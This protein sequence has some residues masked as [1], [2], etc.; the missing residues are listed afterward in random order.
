MKKLS[1]IFFVINLSTSLLLSQV[2][3]KMSYQA[4]VRNTSGNPIVNTMVGIKISILQESASGTTIYAET[5]TPT[6]NQ[7]GLISIEIGSGSPVVGTFSVINWQT[8][9]FFI[10]TE[11]DLLGG[12]NY[13]ITSTT[14]LLSVP[15]SI[16]SKTS[17]SLPCYT[18][19]ERDLLVPSEGIVVFNK[20]SKKPNY[21]DGTIWRNYDNTITTINLTTT[22]LSSVTS[23]SADCGGT[24]ISDGGSTITT[25]GVCWSTSSNPTI[26]LATRT[27]EIND[28]KTFTSLLTGLSGNTTYY[29]RAYATNSAGTDYGNEIV[30]TTPISSSIGDV[31]KGGKI[32]YFL[33]TGDSGYDPNIRHGLIIGNRNLTST[34]WGCDNT[35][36]IGTTLTTLGS[37]L[38][39]TN[40][41]IL[42]SCSQGAAYYCANLVQGGYNDWFLPSVDE[43]KKISTNYVVLNLGNNNSWSSTEKDANNAWYVNFMNGQQ[44]SWGKE[45]TF[46]TYPIRTF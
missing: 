7:N 16:Y 26:N 18:Q 25:K 34:G 15:Y 29:V 46:Y 31:F 39:N 11:I 41:I 22:G 17:G 28:S 36:L 9:V 23:F 27:T 38:S 2:P 42:N 5:Q 44:Y 45:G 40:S 43:L 30:F 21:Y 4:V 35:T 12:S 19:A 20:T 24:I 8:G 33:Q 37:G 3:Q 14:Q 13:T 10:K 32:A 1:I 6:S